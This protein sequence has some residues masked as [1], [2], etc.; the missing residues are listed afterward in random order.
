MF[1]PIP[2]PHAPHTLCP[3]S[4]LFLLTS[5]GMLGSTIGINN[6]YSHY[7]HEDDVLAS[8]ANAT[9]ARLKAIS[10]YD[11][12]IG[13]QYAGAAIAMFML[14]LHVVRIQELIR[15]DGDAVEQASDAIRLEEYIPADHSGDSS[16]LHTTMRSATGS[17]VS[18]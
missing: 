1:P 12:N 5:C 2:A 11:A 9:V 13:L 14:A 4:I 10:C 7:C 15:S 8:D 3:Q 18:P 16:L 17:T 6:Y